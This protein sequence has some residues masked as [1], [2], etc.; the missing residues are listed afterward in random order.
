[1]PTVEQAGRWYDPRDPVHGLDHVLRVLALAERLGSEVGADV[2][3]VRAAALLHDAADAAPA[4]AGVGRTSHE[5]GSAEFAEQILRAE[6][7]PEGRIEAVVHC[8]RAHRFRGQERPRT[9]EAQVLF[10]ADKL[11]VMGAF[12]AAR[13]I[14]YAVQAGTPIYAQPS[15]RF[16]ETGETE[17]E[18][19]HSAYHE[20]LFKLRHVRE[21]LY[22]EPARRLAGRRHAALT[23]FFE[24]MAAEARGEC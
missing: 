7:W 21:R 17:A 3:V 20:Y 23:A 11:D 13:T 5:R 2:D 10:D 24:Q 4:P 18:E 1:M 15:P 8:I 9:L 19:P 14:G 16:L 22:T 12:G 6:G